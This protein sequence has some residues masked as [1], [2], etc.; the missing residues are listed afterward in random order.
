MAD[1]DVV[2]K[3]LTDRSRSVI[4]EWREAN[5]ILRSTKLGLVNHECN[6]SLLIL[7]IEK[8]VLYSGENLTIFLILR[9]T[10]ETP[11]IQFTFLPHALQSG[12]RSQNAR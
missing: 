6:V 8:E 11:I 4:S 1:R 3:T 2:I 10:H 12:G 5:S 7:R 9:E